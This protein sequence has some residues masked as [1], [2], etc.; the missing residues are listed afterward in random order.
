MRLLAAL[1]SRWLVPLS[2]VAARRGRVPFHIPHRKGEAA[3]DPPPRF[4]STRAT[5]AFGAEVC[6]Y[7]CT[8]SLRSVQNMPKLVA[9]AVRDVAGT[10]R[11]HRRQTTSSGCGSVPHNAHR[12]AKIC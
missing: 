3:D 4:H 10:P 8:A 1:G 2:G 6:T 12:C 9:G 7:F 5:L 11:H